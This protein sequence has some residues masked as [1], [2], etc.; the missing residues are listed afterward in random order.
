MKLPRN[1]SGDDLAKRLSDFGDTVTRQT[2]SH[3]RLTTDRKG[4][5]HLTI[6]RHT[7]L[8]VGTL[9]SILADVA[10]HFKMTKHQ[11]TEQLFG[12]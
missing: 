6:P 2:G 10:A 9:S 8:R 7:S 4:E 12:S 3:L 11:L 5:H 1:L